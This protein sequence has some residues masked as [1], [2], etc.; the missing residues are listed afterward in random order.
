MPRAYPRR[1]ASGEPI[2]LIVLRRS[3]EPLDQSLVEKLDLPKKVFSG[4]LGVP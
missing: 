1:N 2:P 4:L 3:Q